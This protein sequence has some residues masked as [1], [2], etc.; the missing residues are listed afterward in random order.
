MTINIYRYGEKYISLH[1]A[2]YDSFP[3]Y[4]FIDRDKNTALY[5]QDFD[6]ILSYINLKLCHRP[7]V[8]REMLERIMNAS[9]LVPPLTVIEGLYMSCPSSRLCISSNCGDIKIE[10]IRDM[11]WEQC[12]TAD[13]ENGD[14]IIEILSK[15]WKR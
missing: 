7:S 6:E 14:R 10:L 2:V 15:F 8:D 4:V 3:W 13:N 5:S 1:H 9:V 11:F 12:H